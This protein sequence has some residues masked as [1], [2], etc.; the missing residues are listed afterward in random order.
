MAKKQRMGDPN[1]PKS[2]PPHIT[3]TSKLSGRAKNVTQRLP[4]LPL[5]ASSSQST[6]T[7]M[8]QVMID[9][10][11]GRSSNLVVNY[12]VAAPTVS[13]QRMSVEDVEMVN[14]E[15]KPTPQR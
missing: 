1:V 9:T 12:G 5:N 6:D 10:E 15:K 3:L 13:S 11:S 14:V 7:I 4:Q 2:E 8:D